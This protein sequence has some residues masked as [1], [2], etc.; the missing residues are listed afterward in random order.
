MQ[1][2]PITISRDQFLETGALL[3]QFN[4]LDRFDGKP[5]DGRINVTEYAKRVERDIACGGVIA[6]NGFVIGINALR[7][8]TINARALGLPTADIFESAILAVDTARESGFL[9]YPSC[10]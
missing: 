1:L 9:R 4:E 10:S 6:H 5:G 8:A 7:L 2:R 3:L